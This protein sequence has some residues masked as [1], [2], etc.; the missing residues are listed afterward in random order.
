MSTP[1]TFPKNVVLHFP[2]S[3]Y[4][5]IGASDLLPQLLEKFVSDEVC[6]VQFL[7]GGRACVAFRK[8]SARDYWLSRELYMFGH[9][10]PVT[11]DQVKL[12]LLYLRDMPHKGHADDLNKFFSANDTALVMER[13][14]CADFPLL[15]DGNSVIKMILEK[16]LPYFL[17]GL[18]LSLSC[19]C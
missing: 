18:R 10:V 2:P 15:F 6:C 4:Q 8:S 13:L 11:R 16:D 17:A 14:T 9:V 7:R 12:S 1:E 3:I 19:I 5:K